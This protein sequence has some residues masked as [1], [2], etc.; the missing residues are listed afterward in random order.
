MRPRFD[1]IWVVNEGVTGE[2]A[3]NFL[4]VNAIISLRK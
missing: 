4:G 1:D 3:S 2:A